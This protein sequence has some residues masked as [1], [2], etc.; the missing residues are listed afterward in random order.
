MLQLNIDHTANLDRCGAS[1]WDGRQRT[2]RTVPCQHLI[3]NDILHIS[4]V[5]CN[6]F[7]VQ[8]WSKGRIDGLIEKKLMIHRLESAMEKS[9]RGEC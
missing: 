9:V 5:E 8:E 7:R 6:I 2:S 1:I 4:L 3:R